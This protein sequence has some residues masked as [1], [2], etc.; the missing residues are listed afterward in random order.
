MDTIMLMNYP[1]HL[2]QLIEALKRLPG[3]GNKSAERFAFQMLE[4]TP[5]HLKLTA[6]LI[7]QLP[8]KL[9][10]CEECGCLIGDEQCAFCQPK[11]MEQ[12]MMCVIASPKDVYAIEE[13]HQFKGVYQVLGFLISPLEGKGP[14]RLPL[15]KLNERIRRLGIREVVIALDSTLEGDATSLYLKRELEPLK[16]NVSRLA[17]GLPMGSS[18]DYVDGG[19]LARAFSGRAAF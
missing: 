12:E 18:L 9:K 1:K 7:S 13:T 2:L 19:T 3:V 5:K 11:R 6:D 10:H 17:L 8:E 16:V 4:W 15:E 14:E